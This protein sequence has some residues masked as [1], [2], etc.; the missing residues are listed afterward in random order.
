MHR[1]NEL[2]ES[3]QRWLEQNGYQPDLPVQRSLHESLN[4]PLDEQ[5][6]SAIRNLLR[7]LKRSPEVPDTPGGG[8]VPIPGSGGV[9]KPFVMDDLVNMLDDFPTSGQ[10][11]MLG[12][13][14]SILNGS[15]TGKALENQMQLYG[16]MFRQ[17][18][19]EFYDNGGN[20]GIREIKG[21][22]PSGNPVVASEQG[23]YDTLA[24][25][26]SD[27]FGQNNIPW[28]PGMV[29][30]PSSISPNFP[31]GGGG[32]FVPFDEI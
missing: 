5:T 9:P 2:S 17:F 12:I 23:F 21:F 18:G 10:G 30:P 15:L 29:I 6:G 27:L 7:L 1:W 24:E 26:L 8:G 31:A 28:S 11:G 4:E 32:R 16:R 13:L 14:Q 3:T 25:I 22:E 19:W 20:V